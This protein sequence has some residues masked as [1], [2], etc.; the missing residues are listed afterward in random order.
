M[1]KPSKLGY[2]NL[3]ARD[4]EAMEN[5]YTNVMG[6]SLVEKGEGEKGILVQV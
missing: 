6:L 3:A 5:Y 2:A 1:K 4:I